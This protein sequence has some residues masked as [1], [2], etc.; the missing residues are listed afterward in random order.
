M[1]RGK[2][3]HTHKRLNTWNRENC[4]CTWDL[5]TSALQRLHK[6]FFWLGV[7]QKPGRFTRSKST[8]FTQTIANKHLLTLLETRDFIK[9][10]GKGFQRKFCKH[11][12]K[13]RHA[14][15]LA[16]PARAQPVQRLCSDWIPI[17]LVFFYKQLQMCC[18]I[19]GYVTNVKIYHSNT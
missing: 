5:E 17:E 15:G 10:P 4:C 1:L 6:T 9:I 19:H 2:D 12:E 14:G 16:A 7:S 13:Q 11:A 18:V 3:T 8:I